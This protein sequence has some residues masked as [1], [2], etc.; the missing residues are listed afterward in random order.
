[1]LYLE[2]KICFQIA[3]FAN[4]NLTATVE[5]GKINT[6]GPTSKVEKTVQVDVSATEI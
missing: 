6:L 1:M 4:Y 3:S 2:F 5:L